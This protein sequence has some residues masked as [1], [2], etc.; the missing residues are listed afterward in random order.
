MQN[1]RFRGFFENEEQLKNVS[2]PSTSVRFEEP[3]DINTLMKTG[4]FMSLPI[5]F[6]SLIIAGQTIFDII[7]N[8][9]C[10]K[11]DIVFSIIF[12]SIIV[13]LYQFVHE[14][15]HALL[16]P[17]K[18]LKE[19]YVSKDLTC[20]FV[21]CTAPVSKLRFIIIAIA[22]NM[23]LGVFPLFIAVLYR[24]MLLPRVSLILIITGFFS[25]I[26]G[27][28]DYCNIYN[29]VCQVPEN[30]YIF[31]SGLHSYWY[32]NGNKL[33]VKPSSSIKALLIL[34]FSLGFILLSLKKEVC[35]AVFF[36]IIMITTLNHG[37]FYSIFKW[38]NLIAVMFAYIVLLGLF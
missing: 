22:P 5:I 11:N 8:C 2:I 33:K 37:F 18:A 15:I 36:I 19:I 24:S 16:F 29:A 31:N 7:V 9:R 4:F 10:E 13:M 20:C 23:V 14:I 6:S 34:F 12:S 26:T 21:Y 35:L 32:E 38:L 17:N 25:I 30:G 3:E 28:G 27:I 1:I